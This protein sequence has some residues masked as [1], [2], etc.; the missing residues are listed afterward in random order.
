MNIRAAARDPGPEPAEKRAQEQRLLETWAAP[1]GWAYWSAVNN[2]D[3]GIWYTVVTFVFFLAAGV[4]GLM[5]RT[6]L[7]VPGNDF[8]SQETYNQVFTMH[9]SVMMFLVAVPFLEAVAIYFLPQM[10]GAR[11]LPFPR[12]SAY[13]FW[14][15]L[16]GG[17]VVFGSIFFGAGPSGG[18]FMYPPLT[19]AEFSPGIGADIWLLGLSFVEI[20]SLAAAV[21]LIIGVLK[22][23]PPGMS[24]NLIPLYAW[25][26]LATGVMILFAFPPLIAGDLLLEMERAFDWP[27]FDPARGGDP[28]L[29]QH[30]FWIFGHPEVYIVFLPAVGVVAMI[31]PTFAGRPVVGYSW[32]VLAAVG[33][34]FISFG[35]WVHH[36]F[37]T[38]LPVISLGFFSAASE[39]VVIPTGVQIFA[40]IAT[41]FA[42]KLRFEPPMLFVMGFLFTFVMG[43]L[44]GVMVAIAPFDW[45]VHDSYFIVAHLHYVLIGGML[46]P[47]FAATYYWMPL[48]SGR[49][50]SLGRP[51]FWLMFAGFHIGFFPMHFTGLMGM[52]RRVY[53]YPE[54][55]G[56]DE[57]NLLSTVGAFV[58]ASGVVLFVIDV[59]QHF[60]RG[61]RAPR[62]PWGAGTLDWMMEMP[63]QDWGA[64][65]VPIVTT[66]YPL[67][68]QANLVDDVDHGRFLI[69]DAPDLR[70]ETII[71]S[72]VDAEPEQV[73]RVPG[74]SWWPLLAAIPTGGFFIAATFHAW[75][76]TGVSGVLAGAAIL[77]WLWTTA[78][79]ADPN[80]RDAGCGYVLPRYVSGPPSVG[81]WAMFI[82]VLAD[83]TA[84][85]SLIFAYFFYWTVSEAWPPALVGEHSL[86]L[87]AAA[88]PFLLLAAGLIRWSV[89]AL[90]LV[91]TG[92][93]KLAVC[94][95]CGALLAAAALQIRWLLGAGLDPT[96]HAYPAIVWTLYGYFLFHVVLAVVMGLYVLARFFA[97]HLAPG[98]DIDLRNVALFW[99]FTV[100]QG[101]LAMATIHLFPLAG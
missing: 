58:F 44:T 99:Y 49:R 36:M 92:R 90:R 34:G 59:V 74:N 56:W 24:I 85:V 23:R 66:R 82:T 31:V 38:G 76:I 22:T 33:T 73:L 71:S 61:E 54:G 12:L 68:Q 100:L 7:A 1:R 2:T 53:T 3:V 21:E 86:L 94:L 10:L 57:L 65:S 70:R 62:N 28:L 79:R 29:W 25:Y 13:G 91:Q 11:D 32:I 48:I 81:W 35:L 93:F 95:G 75:V 60:W 97:G 19:N 41:M 30:L 64:R 63:P 78:E 26:I 55:L 6:Q 40:L 43:G 80:R 96:A 15:Y 27:F 67:W 46:F 4:L 8:L 9:G 20:A 5:M 98:Y 17:S 42:G 84:F 18:W 47:M 39:A 51:T 45:Q 77:G 87:P 101:M 50:M 37:T 14:C 72:V 52:P 69:P 16:I 83:G 89:T 88:A